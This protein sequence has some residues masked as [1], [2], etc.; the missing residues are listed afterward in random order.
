LNT[1]VETSRLWSSCVY[2]FNSPLRFIDP[3]G[4]QRT[5]IYELN[6]KGVVFKTNR[7]GITYNT[8]GTREK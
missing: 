3:D 6:K 1:L 4:R 7:T 2:A 8:N 5:N